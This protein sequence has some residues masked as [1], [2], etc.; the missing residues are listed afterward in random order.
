MQHPSTP[1]PWNASHPPYQRGGNGNGNGL[2]RQ[3]EHRLTVLEVRTDDHKAWLERHHV[4]LG[5]LEKRWQKLVMAA[6]LV[7]AAVL[8]NADGGAIRAIV[9]TALGLALSAL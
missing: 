2:A 6:S 8:A 9:K 1:P 7:L 4:K 5:R 3:T